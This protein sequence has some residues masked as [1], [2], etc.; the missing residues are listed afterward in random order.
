MKNYY[1]S[2]SKL[3]EFL[4]EPTKTRPVEVEDFPWLK[5]GIYYHRLA[6]EE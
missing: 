3:V 6:I 5:E 2:D 1:D 4:I